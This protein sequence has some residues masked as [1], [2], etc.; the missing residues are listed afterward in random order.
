MK[1]LAR[2]AVV[3]LCA[4][5]L[6]PAT[7]RADDGGWWDNFWKFDT[8]FRG[9]GTEFHLLCLDDQGRRV[10]GCE[11]WFRNVKRLFAGQP[12]EHDFKVRKGPKKPGETEADFERLQSFEPV[13]HELDFQV[14]YHQ[15]LGSR[16]PDT[17][18]EPVFDGRI[19]VERV[20]IRYNLHVASWIAVGTGAGFMRVHGADF[21][22]FFRTVITPVSALIYPIKGAKGFFIRP[23]LYIIPKGFTAGD[24]GNAQDPANPGKPFSTFSTNGAEVNWAIAVGFDLR[25][26]G[27]R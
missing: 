1:R 13:R 11:E 25:R 23:D 10:I 4:L 8:H 26:I 7:A 14:S 17:P 18:N 16:Y 20:L 15:S 5:A 12:I 6:A 27:F 9:G 2:V 21:D 19:S 22:P 3:C 24:F